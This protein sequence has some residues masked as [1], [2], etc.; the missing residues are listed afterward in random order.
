M[1]FVD[2]FDLQL[3]IVNQIHD[4][5][6]EIC[7][8]KF[9]IEARILAFYIL[10]EIYLSD[11]MLKFEFGIICV[12]RMLKTRFVGL[13]PSDEPFKDISGLKSALINKQMIRV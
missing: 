12:K 1:L 4:P 11:H 9:D 10:K 6:I 3:T 7:I 5:P 13:T 8:R 2:F